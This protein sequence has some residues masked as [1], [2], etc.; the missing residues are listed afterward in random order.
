[1]NLEKIKKELERMEE[2]ESKILDILLYGQSSGISDEEI[3][4]ASNTLLDITK[5]IIE[6]K[7]YIEKAE[8]GQN[9]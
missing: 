3:K 9:E 2:A 6:L 5:Y 7:E 1:M 4:L 8:G